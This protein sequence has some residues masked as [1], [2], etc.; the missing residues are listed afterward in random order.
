MR[1]WLCLSGCTS[2]QESAERASAPKVRVR[3][4]ERDPIHPGAWRWHLSDL[5][6]AL[7]GTDQRLLRKIF[8]NVAVTAVQ[9]Q[10]THQARVF[11]H[12]EVSEIR[13]RGHPSPPP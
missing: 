8:R 13:R 1:Q 2:L 3:E 9:R 11:R 7:A 4:V 6:P 12:T 5:R 10:S